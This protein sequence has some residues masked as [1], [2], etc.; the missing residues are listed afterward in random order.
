LGERDDDALVVVTLTLKA[1]P[2]DVPADVRLRQLLKRLLRTYR[3]RCVRI[4]P[5]HKREETDCA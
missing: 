5:E 2:D 1:L 4:E 3:F